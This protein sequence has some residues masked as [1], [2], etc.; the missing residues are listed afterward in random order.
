MSIMFRLALLVPMA[1]MFE[2]ANSWGARWCIDP[3][4]R[5]I[6]CI[7]LQGCSS[8]VDLVSCPNWGYFQTERRC[9]AAWDVQNLECCGTTYRNV[10]K[11]ANCQV[12]DVRLNGQK[13]TRVAGCA[14]KAP[15]HPR[16]ASPRAQVR[17]TAAAARTSN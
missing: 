8:S 1:L 15:A 4:V 9:A 13:G 11:V 2:P 17:P 3:D 16:K 5:T 12:L 6:Q 7:D 10:P 14:P